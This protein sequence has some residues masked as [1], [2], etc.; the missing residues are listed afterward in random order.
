MN[1]DIQVLGLEHFKFRAQ[2]RTG[3]LP[4]YNNQRTAQES[5]ISLRVHVSLSKWLRRG[6]V[7]EVEPT[8]T[9]HF[10]SKMCC[11][12]FETCCWHG[13]T[14][15]RLVVVWAI[16]GK[17]ATQERHV[18]WWNAL[19]CCTLQ[20]DFSPISR[21]VIEGRWVVQLCKS[22]ERMLCHAQGRLPA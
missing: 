13:P 11:L 14:V 5:F 19:D 22:G 6:R 18:R 10:T 4:T 3:P 8:A 7:E 17:R 20:N 9:R 2:V 16:P 12:V 1:F 15:R 21:D